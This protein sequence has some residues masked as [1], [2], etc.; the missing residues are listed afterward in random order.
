MNRLT[1]R[2]TD[3]NVMAI[4]KGDETYIFLFDDDN[5]IETLKQTGRFAA[6]QALSFSWH[7]AAII[8]Q[9]IRKMTSEKETT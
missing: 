7:D 9:R 2:N 3:I 5:R 1:S 8:S 6:N 4:V